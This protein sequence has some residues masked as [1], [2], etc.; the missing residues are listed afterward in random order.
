[1]IWRRTIRAIVTILWRQG[2][3]ARC[4]RQFWTQLIGMGWQNPSRIVQYFTACVMGEDLS[5]M[6]QVVREKVTAIIKER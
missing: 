3:R 6:R 1:M 5:Y 2:V 4:R